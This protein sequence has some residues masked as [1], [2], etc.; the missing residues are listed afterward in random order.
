MRRQRKPGPALPRTRPM[1]DR[2][3]SNVQTFG[4]Q[5]DKLCHREGGPASEEHK[6]PLHVPQARVL[7]LDVRGI[8]S[9]DAS[10]LYQKMQELSMVKE[11]PANPKRPSREFRDSRAELE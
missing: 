8:Q 1:R 6:G 5:G 3:T 2:Q 9:L 11:S 4:G 7:K 10:S